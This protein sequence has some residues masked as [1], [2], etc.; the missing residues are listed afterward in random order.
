[1]PGSVFDCND[2]ARGE[3][4]S[5]PEATILTLGAGFP[6]HEQIHA[7]IIGGGPGISVER[8][9]GEEGRTSRGRCQE[10]QE[11]E[12]TLRIEREFIWWYALTQPYVC[13]ALTKSASRCIK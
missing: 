5:S 2:M 9:R 3:H 11:E 8:A 7:A 1:M 12:I 6:A 4:S 13:A 10:W